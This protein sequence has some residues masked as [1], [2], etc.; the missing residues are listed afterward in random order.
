MVPVSPTSPIQ[1]FVF[2]GIGELLSLLLCALPLAE[3]DST[4]LHGCQAFANAH[5][6]PPPCPQELNLVQYAALLF[7]RICD[8]SRYMDYTRLV[9]WRFL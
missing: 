3:W 7:G 8:V 9:V 1:G 5:P 2:V 6:T 4:H